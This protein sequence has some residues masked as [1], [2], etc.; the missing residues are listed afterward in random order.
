MSQTEQ[1]ELSRELVEASQRVISD[2]SL[3]NKRDACSKRKEWLA[4]VERLSD[5]ERKNAE[6]S[7]Y[8]ERLS[9]KY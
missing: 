3:D 6:K 8:E 4:K 9:A 1:A 7:Y 2:P 5:A